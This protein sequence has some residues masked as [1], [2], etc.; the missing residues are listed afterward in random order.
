MKELTKVEE[1]IMI[2]LWKIHSGCVNDI[3][4]KINEP[5]PKYTTISTIVR[6]L[7]DKGFVSHKKKGRAHIYYPL[8]D[9]KSYAYFLLNNLSSTYF[10]SSMR[11]MMVFS[12][13]E[14]KISVSELEELRNIINDEINNQTTSN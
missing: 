12:L 4:S 2:V 1:Q 9:K 6:I 8:I 11:Q 13:R 10:G 5:K 3:I 14:K 7:E